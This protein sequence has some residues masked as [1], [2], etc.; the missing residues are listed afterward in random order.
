MTLNF[1]MMCL[2]LG[3]DQMDEKLN[4]TLEKLESIES[5][6]P[7]GTVNVPGKTVVVLRYR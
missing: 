4:K 6:L 3:G 7:A 5:R 1:Q 2:F